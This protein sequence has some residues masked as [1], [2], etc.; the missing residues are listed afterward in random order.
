[1][2]R[3]GVWGVLLS[4]CWGWPQEQAHVKEKEQ[5]AEADEQQAAPA[6]P[7]NLVLC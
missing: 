4:F 5:V 2:H 7:F 1:M 6:T 3:T